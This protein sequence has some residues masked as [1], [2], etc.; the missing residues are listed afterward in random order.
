[1][2]K[3][4]TPQTQIKAL[5]AQVATGFDFESSYEGIKNA[6]PENRSFLTRQVMH[7]F[8]TVEQ[9]EKTQKLFDE[10]HPMWIVLQRAKLALPKNKVGLN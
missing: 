1:M 4:Q 8:T 3:S 7:F 9:F 6:K 5:G 2:Q 10:K